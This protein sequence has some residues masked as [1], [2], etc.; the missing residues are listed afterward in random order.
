M[1]VLS[2]TF[3]ALGLTFLLAS[4]AAADID[5]GQYRQL[6]RD[7]TEQLRIRIESVELL[8][9]EDSQT[10]YKVV[11]IVTRAERSG[12]GLRAGDRV[13]FESYTTPRGGGFVGPPSP[14][15]PRT[16]WQGRVYLRDKA[17]LEGGEG[18]IIGAYGQSYE[19]G[20]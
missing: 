16:G 3:T 9:E 5:P 19:P 14:M 20:R 6:K 4:T 10:T 11:A 18:L 13:T 12:T 2:R 8:A 15:K 7:A 1:N 17:N